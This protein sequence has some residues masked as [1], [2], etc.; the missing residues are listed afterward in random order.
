MNI[1]IIVLLGPVLFRT[2]SFGTGSFEDKCRREEN[3]NNMAK[4]GIIRISVVVSI[5]FL[6]MTTFQII[7][8]YQS[9]REERREYDLECQN[10]IDDAPKYMESEMYYKNIPFTATNTYLQNT[11]SEIFVKNLQMCLLCSI[12]LFLILAIRCKIKKEKIG[13]ENIAII[14]W[15]ILLFMMVNCILF[16]WD[17]GV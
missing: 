17:R 7:K 10:R 5:I 8:C 4:K 6:F 13:K 3:V 2:C 16:V 15:I 14:S 12:I 9:V 1:L 11:I